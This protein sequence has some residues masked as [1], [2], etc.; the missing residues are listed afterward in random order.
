[1]TQSDGIEFDVAIVVDAQVPIRRLIADMLRRADIPLVQHCSSPMEALRLIS[2]RPNGV[3][4]CTT[5]HRACHA[6]TTALRWG[7]DSPARQVPVVAL[8]RKPTK[9]SVMQARDHGIN[10]VVMVPVSTAA[11]LQMVQSLKK[12]R[13]VHIATPAYCGPDRRRAAKEIPFEDRRLGD[14]D[15]PRY[16]RTCAG[17]MHSFT[18]SKPTGGSGNRTG[19]T[20]LLSDMDGPGSGGTTRELHLPIEQLVPGMY[21]TEP[22]FTHAGLEV[23]KD[24]QQLTTRIIRRLIDLQTADEIPDRVH[25]VEIVEAEDNGPR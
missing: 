1:M 12:S 9:A 8:D 18:R 22:V 20:V 15:A 2:Q 14:L 3:I 25:I 19:A 13:R 24:G 6:L 23:I 17:I 4:F 11:V 16:T 7:S 10:G 21:L 5:S